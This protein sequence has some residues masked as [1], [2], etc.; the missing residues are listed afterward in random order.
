MENPKIKTEIKKQ[1]GRK[2]MVTHTLYEEIIVWCIVEKQREKK[3]ILIMLKIWRLYMK[4]KEV[5]GA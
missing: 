3:K 4:K 5:N 2:N 1:E